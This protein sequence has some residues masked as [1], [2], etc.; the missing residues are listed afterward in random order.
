MSQPT[1]RYMERVGHIL[2]HIRGP[3]RGMHLYQGNSRSNYLLELPDLHPPPLVPASFSAS[4]PLRV[5]AAIPLLHHVYRV[6]WLYW[7]ALHGNLAALLGAAMY[8]HCSGNV[9]RGLAFTLEISC[10]SEVMVR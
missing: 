8:S 2:D 9:R 7:S 5:P 3:A 6:T 1:S 10:Q 4:V